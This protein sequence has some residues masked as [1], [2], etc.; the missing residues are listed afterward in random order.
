[1]IDDSGAARLDVQST[2][3][4][5]NYRYS[6]P[7][8]RFPLDRC[9]GITPSTFERDIFGM[10]MIIYEAS[11]NSPARNQCQTLFQVLTGGVPYSECDD[12]VALSQI[13]AGKM[14]ERPSGGITDPV[15]QLL[16]ECWS[17]DPRER[18]STIQV[19][20][21]LSIFRAIKV[22]PEKLK[23]VVQ[24][25]GVPFT[26]PRP[27]QV[28]VKFKYGNKDHATSLTTW[29]SAGSEYIWSTFRPSLQSLLSLNLGQ[30]P[31]GSMADRNQ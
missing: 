11:S 12:I 8:T 2:G 1:L 9:K 24:S 10:G 13:R 5:D 31:S 3:D 19:Y 4:I 28:S 26:T 18:P 21:T 27:Q 29:T 25:I 20:N 6:A 30:E 22:L 15:W 16:E 14:P 23:L 7:E 17:K